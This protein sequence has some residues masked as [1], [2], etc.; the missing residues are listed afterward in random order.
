MLPTLMPDDYVI[1]LRCNRYQTGQMVVVQH[2]SLGII[3]KRIAACYAVGE[4]TWRYALCGDNPAS[5]SMEAMGLVDA[6]QLL[7]RVIWTVRQTR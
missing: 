2:D 6:E 7:G 5:T 4:G 3:V 1:C